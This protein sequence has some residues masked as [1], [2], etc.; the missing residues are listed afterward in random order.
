MIWTN[1]IILS[2]EMSPEGTSATAESL[3]PKFYTPST[4]YLFR[5]IDPCRSR[6]P[7]EVFPF[8]VFLYA[9]L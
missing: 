8:A 1:I 9:T 4:I 6:A 5:N 2:T 7:R 3:I